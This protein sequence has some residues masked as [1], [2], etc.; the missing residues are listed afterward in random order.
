MSDM[1]IPFIFRP[2]PTHSHRIYY[3]IRY[4]YT[5]TIKKPVG[6]DNMEVLTFMC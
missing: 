5:L 1:E 4:V 3:I 2:R 6:E